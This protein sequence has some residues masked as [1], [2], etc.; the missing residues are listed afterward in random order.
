VRACIYIN[1]DIIQE[2][3]RHGAKVD[4]ACRVVVIVTIKCKE[5]RRQSAQKVTMGSHS[6]SKAAS[7]MMLSN[8]AAEGSRARM[9][10]EIWGGGNY[11]AWSQT[12]GGNRSKNNC[13]RDR[14]C[15]PGRIVHVQFRFSAYVA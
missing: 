11:A 3:T 8:T 12:V 4:G 2:N 9:F 7:N 15:S 14:E 1:E 10:S 5:F 13:V 6:Q